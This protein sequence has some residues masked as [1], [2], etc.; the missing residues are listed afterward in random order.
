MQP[1]SLLDDVRDAARTGCDLPE[2]YVYAFLIDG[3][4]L[5]NALDRLQKWMSA[6]RKEEL[7][8]V[9]YAMYSARSLEGSIPSVDEQHAAALRRSQEQRAGYLQQLRTMFPENHEVLAYDLEQAVQSGR[10]LVAAELLSRAKPIADH[11]HRFWRA[12]GWLLMGAGDLDGAGD[13]FREALAVHPL[14]WRLRHYLADLE[15]RRGNLSE[16]EAAQRLAARG[17]ALESDLLAM[18]DVRSIPAETLRRM[19]DFATACGATLCAD[20]IRHHADARDSKRDSL[21][22]GQHTPSGPE[23][24]P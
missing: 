20:R 12:R 14:D 7:L 16:A 8:M 21:S 2:F 15:R 19:A 6:G 13:A 4:R 23:S 22:A 17:R 18:S 3:L 1:M 10:S 5:H 11:D 24:P 9:A